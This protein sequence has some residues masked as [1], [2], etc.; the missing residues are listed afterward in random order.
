[1]T[2]PTSWP[3]HWTQIKKALTDARERLIVGKSFSA[4]KRDC[5]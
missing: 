2:A 3:I 1:M 5:D 4:P